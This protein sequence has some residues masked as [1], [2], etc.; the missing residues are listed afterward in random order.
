MD[1]KIAPFSLLHRYSSR[2]CDDI[3]GLIHGTLAA[4]AEVRIYPK[5]DEGGVV[6]C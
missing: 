3:M 1:N 6:T 4:Y 5:R 2:A